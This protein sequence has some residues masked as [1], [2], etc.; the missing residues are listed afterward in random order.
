MFK[1]SGSRENIGGKKPGKKRNRRGK[2]DAS[3]FS[4]KKGEVGES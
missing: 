1:Q 2:S 4:E 3:H